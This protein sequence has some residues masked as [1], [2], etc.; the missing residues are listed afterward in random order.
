LRIGVRLTPEGL[1]AHAWVESDGSPINDRV[2]IGSE[3]S[4]FEGPLPHESFRT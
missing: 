2:D 4:A 1:V 3:Y